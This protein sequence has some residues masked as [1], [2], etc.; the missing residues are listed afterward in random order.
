MNMVTVFP[1]AS[2]AFLQSFAPMQRP[3]ITVA[4]IANPTST[5]VSICM[6]W[7]PID[8]AVVLLTR[9]NCPTIN[10]SAIPYSVCKKYDNRYGSEKYTTVL[11]TFPV[12]KSLS[13]IHIYLLHSRTQGEGHSQFPTAATYNNGY[14]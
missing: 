7:L 2:D 1:I 6:I 11:N 14:F 3:I 10:K 8:T 13:L 9:P 12:V 4:H 5:T